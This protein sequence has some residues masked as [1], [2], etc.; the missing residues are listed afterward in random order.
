MEK[1]SFNCPACNHKFEYD[2]DMFG[3]K[4]CC[5]NIDCDQ[6]LD[7]PNGPPGSPSAEPAEPEPVD[8]ASPPPS[9]LAS[10]PPRTESSETGYFNAAD[11]ESGAGAGTPAPSGDNAEPDAQAPTQEKGKKF[12]MPPPKVLILGALLLA[13]LMV[14]VM[15]LLPG[16][17]PPPLEASLDAATANAAAGGEPVANA[18]TNAPAADSDPEAEMSAEQAEAEAKAQA[19]EEAAAK[20]REESLARAKAKAAAAIAEAEA[21]AREEAEA[22]AKAEA[23]A[24]A[25]AK[26]EARDKARAKISSTLSVRGITGS[27]VMINTGLK[28]YPMEEGEE[29]KLTTTDGKLTV[30]IVDIDG[31]TVKMK[32]GKDEEL[33][34]F[35]SP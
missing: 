31:R 16:S 29:R 27:V 15:S 8:A 1:F 19:E 20:A 6:F 4:T 11:I 24:K 22:K 33:F 7:I 26:A 12:K 14:V 2:E 32:V 35:F 25:K 30:K 5:P 34:T 23:E 21:K 10:M 13:V 28:N 9:E 3:L 17:P 18:D